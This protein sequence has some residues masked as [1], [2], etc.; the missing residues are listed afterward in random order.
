[1]PTTTPRQIAEAISNLFGPKATDLDSERPNHMKQVE[2]RVLQ[3]LLD[4]LPNDLITLSDIDRPEFE[5]CRAS[6]ATV[7]A[8]WSQANNVAVPAVAAKNPVERIRRLLFMCANELPRL[9][10]Q[11]RFITDD[12]YRLNAEAKIQAAWAD[13]KANEWLGATVFAGCALEAIL[14]WE[15]KRA[16]TAVQGTANKL[17]L[18]ELI[19]KAAAAGLITPS[20]AKLAEVAKDGRDLLHPGRVARLRTECTKATSLTPLAAVEQVAEE[21]GTAFAVSRNY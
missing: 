13:F 16:Y 1:M 6:L 18:V 3:A 20:A 19:K 9:N 7:L 11:F 10:P 8:F 12:D 15:V 5:Q 17:H 14:L 21:L 4:D 2:V